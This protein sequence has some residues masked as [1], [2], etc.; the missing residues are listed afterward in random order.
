[1][2]FNYTDLDCFY[3][4]NIY[5][6]IEDYENIIYLIRFNNDIKLKKYKY[7]FSVNWIE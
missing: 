3:N 4:S 6:K 2:K 1:M 5:E 7:T